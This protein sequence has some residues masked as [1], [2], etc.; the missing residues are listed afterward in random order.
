MD[1]GPDF[2][3]KSKPV[4]SRIIIEETNL[5]W[6]AGTY[7]HVL[8]RSAIRFPLSDEGRGERLA[9]DR[10]GLCVSA[11]RGAVIL[12]TP[13][14]HTQAAPPPYDSVMQDSMQGGHQFFSASVGHDECGRAPMQLGF[15]GLACPGWGY[16]EAF[17]VLL[18][19]A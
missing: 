16:N 9:D 11:P 2:L 8:L 13:P 12:I 7:A 17:L 4:S 10:L 18:G 6:C 5:P 15:L 1:A 19:A 14:T 3:A